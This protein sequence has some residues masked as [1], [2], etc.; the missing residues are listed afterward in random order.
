MAIFLRG[1]IWWFEYRTRRVRIVK[2]T[3]F[4]K[5]D[6]A[7]AL[8]VFNAFKLGFTVKPQRSVMEKMLSAIYEESDV[9]EKGFPLSSVWLVYEDWFKGKA[10]KV[11]KS[12]W[13]NVRNETARLI[14]WC[15][16]KGLTDISDVGVPVARDYV[17]HIYQGRSNKT[18]RNIAMQLSGVWDAVGQIHAGVHNPW[19]AACPDKDGTAVRRLNFTD[20]EV[21]RVLDA[22]KEAGHGWY[23]ASM[24]AL[25]TGLR[26]GDIALLAWEDIDLEAG[27]IRVT[28]NK[29]RHSSGVVV[30]IP[31]AKPLREALGSAS[32]GFVLPEHAMS[33]ETRRKLPMGFTSV[34]RG[35]GIDTKNHTFHSWRHTANSR[36][37]EAG[38]SS[39]V[40]RMLCGWTNDDMAR[41][42]DHA[43]HLK[44]LQEAVGAI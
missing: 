9:K 16:A 43:K 10:K 22:A 25:Y 12:T 21:V 23:L 7:K 20:E 44:E 32:D 14:D 41:H 28:P 31:I 3:G 35:A 18:V 24:I 2:S 39:E 37:A 8:A 4:R 1:N 40:R 26:Y 38:I 15:V 6:K 17:K 13:A 11:A 30:T 27:L 33:Y 34:L 5:P 36:M 42:Y 29:T 19:K